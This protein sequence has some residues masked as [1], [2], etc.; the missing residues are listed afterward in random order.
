MACISNPERE[1]PRVYSPIISSIHPEREL[2]FD[3]LALVM[4]RVLH[5]MQARIDWFEDQLK[6]CNNEI[7]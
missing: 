4:V 6:D 1:V 2:S 5:S 7:S 3:E